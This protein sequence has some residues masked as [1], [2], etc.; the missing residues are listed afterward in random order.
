MVPEPPLRDRLEPY[1]NNC[2]AGDQQIT[3]VCMRLPAVSIEFQV[4]HTLP[5]ETLII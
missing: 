2:T 3:G 1:W 4:I 5:T